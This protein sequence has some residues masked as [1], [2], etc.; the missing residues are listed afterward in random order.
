MNIAD[1]APKHINIDVERSKVPTYAG[2]FTELYG[3]IKAGKVSLVTEN[4]GHVIGIYVES[5]T[6]IIMLEELAGKNFQR[7]YA[8]KPVDRWV[9]IIINATHYGKEITNINEAAGTC[10][11]DGEV[12]TYDASKASRSATNSRDLPESVEL[13]IEEDLGGDASNASIKAYLRETYDHYLSGFTDTP[14]QVQDHEEG[15]NSGIITITD[16]CW[17]RKR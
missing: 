12:I 11:I 10:V 8:G 15:D 13:D 17:G 6:N 4:G 9:E 16:I 1:Y 7:S 2:T 5:G 3:L 14:F